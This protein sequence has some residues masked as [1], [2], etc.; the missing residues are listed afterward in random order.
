MLIL[1]KPGKFSSLI[2]RDKEKMERLFNRKREE[3]KQLNSGKKIDNSIESH[4]LLT[5]QELAK[6][7]EKLSTEMNSTSSIEKNENL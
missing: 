4:F 2:L 5:K 1:K 3:P 7:L 6:S